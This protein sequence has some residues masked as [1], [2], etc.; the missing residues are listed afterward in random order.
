MFIAAVTLTA[1]LLAGVVIVL[2]VERLS[3]KGALWLFVPPTVGILL[4]L[5]G[6]VERR[7]RPVIG[8]GLVVVGVVVLAVYLLVVSLF[9]YGASVSQ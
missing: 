5:W 7:R 9:W 1:T 6:T 3:V 4:T 8:T 2:S